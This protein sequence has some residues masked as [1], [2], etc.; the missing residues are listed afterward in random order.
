MPTGYTAKLMDEGQ[1]FRAFVLTCAR[2]MGACIMQRD[3]P[4]SDPPKKETA[5]DYHTKRL[6]EAKATLATLKA[7][8][9]EQRAAHGA[10]LRD[11][12]TK[13]AREYLATAVAQ[14]ERL[15]AMAAQVSAWTPPTDE[16]KGLRDFMLEQIK[17][18]RNDT[19]WS[20]RR[21]EE[22]VAKSV[23]AYFVEALSSA[24]RRHRIPRATPAGRYWAHTRPQHVDRKALREPAMNAR[25]PDALGPTDDLDFQRKLRA[26]L[27]VGERQAVWPAE[28]RAPIERTCPS[29]GA[30]LTGPCG[31]CNRSD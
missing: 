1:D 3:D 28:H 30:K 19:S 8:T 14:N 7:M 18:S 15:D 5:S 9:S 13:S 23:E 10:G 25:A 2:A 22:A 6:A 20:E 17:I 11:A 31:A 21:A 16:H 4:M 24:V 26:V 12:A 29:C 27:N